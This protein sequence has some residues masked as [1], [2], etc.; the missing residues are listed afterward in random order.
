[1]KACMTVPAC[2]ELGLITIKT[3]WKEYAPAVK[4]EE[5]Y[6]AVSHREYYCI[7]LVPVILANVSISRQ[8]ECLAR[9][10]I[11]EESQKKKAYGSRY[12]MPQTRPL[13]AEDL[14][15]PSTSSCSCPA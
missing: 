15:S 4:S 7:L 1:M 2:R 3:R 13:F 14:C 6:L 11:S 9:Q 10:V 12:T 8:L 5:A